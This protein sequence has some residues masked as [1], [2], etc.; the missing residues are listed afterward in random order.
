MECLEKAAKIVLEALKQT[1]IV[2]GTIV[3]TRGA[4]RILKLKRRRRCIGSTSGGGT[5]G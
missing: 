2:Q 3:A 1:K 4:A 5:S